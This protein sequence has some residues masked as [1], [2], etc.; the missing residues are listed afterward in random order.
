MNVDGDILL[1]RGTFQGNIHLVS[2][3][4]DDTLSIVKIKQEKVTF[5]LYLRLLYPFIKNIKKNPITSLL[6]KEY[7]T[8]ES[9][10]MKIDLQFAR[11]GRLRDDEQSWPEKNNLNL[12]GFIYQKLGTD[13][14]IK[15]LKD[16]KTRLKWLRLQPEFF[17]QTYEQLAEVLKKEGDP[18]AATEILIHKERDIRPK[19]NRLSK[20]WNRF[21]DITIAYGYKPTKALVWSSIF[22]SIGWNLFAL[23]YDNCSNSISNNKCLF[24]PASEISPYTEETN[25]KTIDID[26]PEFNFW[27]YSLDTFIPIVD[28]HQQTY[29]LPNSQKGEEIPLILFKVKAGRLLRWYLWVHIIFGWILTSLWVAGFSGLVRG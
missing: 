9:H 26:Y 8:I 21:L 1:D 17:P 2:A 27:L 20:F 15:V 22:I 18:D 29:W 19:L 25:N 3:R 7:Q 24:S 6:Q 28:L 4:V 11:I 16:A 13:D 23:G 5:P 10:Y 12:D 14:N